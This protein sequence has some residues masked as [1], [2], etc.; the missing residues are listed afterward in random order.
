MTARPLSPD[1]KKERAACYIASQA[2]LKAC[3]E[4][5]CDE[6]TKSG[7]FAAHFARIAACNAKYSGT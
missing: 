1:G 5:A 7:C 3:V 4:S 2:I 6:S